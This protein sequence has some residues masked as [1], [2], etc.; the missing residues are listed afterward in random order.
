VAKPI[1]RFS[2]VSVIIIKWPKL[3]V[4][5]WFIMIALVLGFRF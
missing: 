5:F 4:G 2:G 3:N 1:R